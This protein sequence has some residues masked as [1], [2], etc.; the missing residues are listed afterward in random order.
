MHQPI[1]AIPKLL[2]LTGPTGVGKT[3]LSLEISQLFNCEIISSD[4]MQVYRH[5]DIGTAKATV[6]ERALVPHHLIDIIDPD[7]DY[8]AACYERDSLAAVKKI[9]EKGRVPLVTGGTGLYIQALC[10]GIFSDGLS[11]PELKKQLANRIA[12]EGK[13][14]IYQELCKVDPVSAERIHPNDTLR[15]IRGLEI[16]QGS[17]KRWSDHLKDQKKNEYTRFPERLE[18]GL[19]C[20]RDRLYDRINRRTEMM[21]EAGFEK[22]VRDLLA[23]GYGEELKPMQS[24]GYRHMIQYIKGEWSRSQTL[25]LMAR[26]TRR[27]AKR[28]YTW[29][30]N[31]TSLKWF[32]VEDR[33]AVLKV[34][35]NWCREQN[36]A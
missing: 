1:P 18:I 7:E 34:I 8:D 10:Q 31:R 13:E 4:S 32:D 2:I 15:I 16:F 19:T 6:D 36:I 3:D 11:F 29:F 14:A 22:E 35:Q 17:G 24:I 21:F 27:Y 12:T 26:D 23:Q 20:E 9:F 5:M 25:E 28:Q 33:T 30:N